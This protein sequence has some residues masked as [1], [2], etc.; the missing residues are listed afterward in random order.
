MSPSNIFCKKEDR[1]YHKEH[2]DE[3]AKVLKKAHIKMNKQMN[4][5][6]SAL[7]QIH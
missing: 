3:V 1:K 5:K 2:R 7:T 4:P 6:I